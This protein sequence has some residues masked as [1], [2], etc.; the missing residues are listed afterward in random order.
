MGLRDMVKGGFE[1]YGGIGYMKD[2]YGRRRL[3]IG[4][5]HLVL[6]NPFEPIG[7]CHLVLDTNR[8][9]LV[10]VPSICR[11]GLSN[12]RSHLVLVPHLLRLAS[13]INDV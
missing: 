9:L 12:G 8:F 1:R 11:L 2:D 13:F 6:I 5:C 10:F 7:G 4:G 3:S